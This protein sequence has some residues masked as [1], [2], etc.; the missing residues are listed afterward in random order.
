MGNQTVLS[1]TTAKAAT[2]PGLLLTY[3]ERMEVNPMETMDPDIKVKWQPSASNEQVFNGG[4]SSVDVFQLNFGISDAVIEAAL[5]EKHFFGEQELY[6]LIAALL[7][8]PPD[9][10]EEA[11]FGE[12]AKYLFYTKDYVV[13]VWLASDEGWIVEVVERGKWGEWE[14]G[15]TYVCAPVAQP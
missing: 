4:R 15:L 13:E 2:L 7:K 12:G 6:H 10:E 9:G 8:E 3:V 14:E 1:R 11:L 5:P